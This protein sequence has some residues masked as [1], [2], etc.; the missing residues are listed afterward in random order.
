MDHYRGVEHNGEAERQLERKIQ[1]VEPAGLEVFSQ[2]DPQIDADIRHHDDTS[3][4]QPGYRQHEQKNRSQRINRHQTG[5]E[6]VHYWR[7][8]SVTE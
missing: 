6:E 3:G 5:P 7:N 1:D 4:N 8:R 2:D